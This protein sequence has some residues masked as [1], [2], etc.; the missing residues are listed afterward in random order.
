MKINCFI[1][2]QNTDEVRETIKSLKESPLVADI[3]LL[4]EAGSVPEDTACRLL[5]V[6]S[7]RS[8]T[9]IKSI[10]AQS[11]AD[12]TLIYTKSLELNFGYFALE[13]ML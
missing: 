9:T 12:Y 5:P 3:Y 6:D 7:L 8:T 1:P 10:A 2:Y 13:R 4:A 11:D